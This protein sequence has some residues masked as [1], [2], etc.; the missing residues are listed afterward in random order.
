[1]STT[2]ELDVVPLVIPVDLAGELTGRDRVAAYA[3]VKSGVFPVL[4]GPG[5]KRVPTAA[6]D[7]LV[8]RR[9]TAADIRAAEARLEPKRAAFRRYQADYRAARTAVA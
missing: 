6:I 9:I 3:A 7:Q 4:P 8:G 1:M 2:S 5:R